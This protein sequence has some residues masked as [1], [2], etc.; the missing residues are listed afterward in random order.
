LLLVYNLLK[1][2]VHLMSCDLSDLLILILLI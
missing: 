1:G 2:L